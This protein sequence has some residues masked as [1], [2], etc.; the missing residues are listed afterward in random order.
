MLQGPRYVLLRL[1][2]CMVFGHPL[3][4]ALV[5]ISTV[6]SKTR[7][8]QGYQR[9]TLDSIHGQRWVLEEIMEEFISLL[10]LF[11]CITLSCVCV[12]FKCLIGIYM[13][14]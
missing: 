13:L 1:I 8:N 4:T 14:R 11:R 7:Q 3:A 10:T 12:V 5:P 2:K 6:S 9:I